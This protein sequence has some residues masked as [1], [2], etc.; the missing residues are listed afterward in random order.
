MKNNTF[1]NI[2]YFIDQKI[3]CPGNVYVY[4]LFLVK[5]IL[6]IAFSPKNSCYYIIIFLTA[7]KVGFN[8]P[9]TQRR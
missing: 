2:Y 8:F 3:F 9:C 4:F 7:F 5:S 6:E 1:Q